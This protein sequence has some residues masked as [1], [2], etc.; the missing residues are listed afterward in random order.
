MR[1]LKMVLITLLLTGLIASQ[2]KAG[3]RAVDGL[4]IGTAVGATVGYI[5]GNE[6]DKNGYGRAYAYG[7]PV[8]YHQQVTYPYSHSPR[9]YYAPRPYYRDRYRDH[10]RPTTA[11]T[12]DLT[13]VPVRLAGKY[14]TSE[15][16]TDIT[17][18]HTERSAV[19]GVTG[20][21]PGTGTAITMA[22]TDDITVGKQEF[23]RYTY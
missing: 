5:V 13:T 15:Y 21:V 16:G 12:T 23:L 17:M 6:M 7:P 18:R 2:A 4:L 22:D 11:T 10:Y 3:D 19:T 1:S 9:R 14:W 20:I 8:V